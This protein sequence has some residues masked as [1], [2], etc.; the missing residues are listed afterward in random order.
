M[1]KYFDDVKK[2]IVDEVIQNL[3]AFNQRLYINES[4]IAEEIQSRIDALKAAQDLETNYDLLVPTDLEGYDNSGYE[5]LIKEE[6]VL[7]DNDE[8][9]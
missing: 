4:N 9:L 8:N 1:N 5:Q 3:Q 2:D 6:F 7:D